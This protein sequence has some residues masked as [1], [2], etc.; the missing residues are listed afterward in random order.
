[1]R[2]APEQAQALDQHLI[3]KTCFTCNH[4]SLSE[5]EHGLIA[6]ASRSNFPIIDRQFGFMGT[7]S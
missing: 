1:M 7:W 2:S 4:I 3:G 6:V 5:P